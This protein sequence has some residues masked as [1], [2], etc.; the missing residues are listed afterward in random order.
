MAAGRS[1]ETIEVIRQG[2]RLEFQAGGSAHLLVYV[3]HKGLMEFSLESQ[4]P[5]SNQVQAR[6]AVVLAC[7]SKSYKRIISTTTSSSSEEHLTNA[8]TGRCTAPVRLVVAR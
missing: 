7:A 6:S 1:P 5:D 3:G 8:L 2:D 4:R